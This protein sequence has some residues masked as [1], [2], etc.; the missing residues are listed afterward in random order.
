[1][2]LIKK[3]RLKTIL[4]L[5]V[6][7]ATVMFGYALM[8]LI[9][10]AMVAPLGDAALASLGIGTTIFILFLSLSE[11]IGSGVQALV[12]RRI[13]EEKPHLAGH[14]LNIGLLITCC[15]NIVLTVIC[16]LL[17]PFL[18]SLVSQ[19]PEVIEKG[20]LYLGAR[21]PC[22][23]LLGFN[24]C[25]RAFWNGMGIPK[26]PLLAL[27]I[28]LTMNVIFNYLLILG[29]LGFPRLETMGAGLASALAVVCSATTNIILALKYARKNGFL[30]KLPNIERIQTL[31]RVSLPESANQFLIMLGVLVIYGIVALLGTKELAASNVLLNIFLIVHLPTMG[32]GIASLTLVGQ[33]LGRKDPQ[34]A[35]K[36]GWE[37]AGV[38]TTGVIVFGVIM[39]SFPQAVLSIFIS[40]QSTIDLALIPLQLIGLSAWIHAFGVIISFSL[41]GA[42]A[43]K[44]VMICTF[45]FFWCLDLP[46]RWLVGVHLQYGLEAMFITPILV[47]SISSLYFALIWHRERWAR[48]KI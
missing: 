10:I 40:D 26:W 3:S 30:K 43:T 47:F 16:Y 39:V 19:D 9:D 38:G 1:M 37:V 20:V 31:L 22:L 41:I 34:D 15:L 12:A 25:F 6:P 21:I 32:F 28:A 29:N 8:G 11:G 13:G 45:I 5:A 17:L 44:I 18:F 4:N 35:K 7:I 2:Q 24:I 46:L 23:T 48:I 42:G 27:G 36:W 33:A 14:D